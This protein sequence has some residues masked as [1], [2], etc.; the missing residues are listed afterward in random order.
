[1]SAKLVRSHIRILA[2]H[3]SDEAQKLQAMDRLSRF[4]PLAFEAVSKLGEIANEHDTALQ[5]AALRCLAAIGPAS[6]SALTNATTALGAS[7]TSVRSAAF[8]V[9]Q[10]IGPVSIPELI[11]TVLYGKS[12]AKV[13]AIRAIGALGAEGR[14][15]QS[16]LAHL[17]KT[18]KR[19]VQ[20]AAANALV[21]LE[22]PSPEIIASASEFVKELPIEGKLSAWNSLTAW[23]E[24]TKA[25]LPQMKKILTK[26][27]K[28]GAADHRKVVFKLM[29]KIGPAAEPLAENLI[30]FFEGPENPLRSAALIAAGRVGSAAPV[31]AILQ[32]VPTA[33]DTRRPQLIDALSR[34]PS[35]GPQLVPIIRQFLPTAF[36]AFRETLFAA[37]MRMGESATDAIPEVAA[38]LHDP[39]AN[40]RSMALRTL[41]KLGVPTS[42]LPTIQALVTDPQPET[43]RLAMLAI[44]RSTL[45]RETIQ[46]AL[47]ERLRDD[48]PQVRHLAARLLAQTGSLP[49][50]LLAST[51]DQLQSSYLE[52]RLDAATWLWR[53]TKDW[54]A[55]AGIF[56]Q[57]ITCSNRQ[58]RRE[59]L[60]LLEE[61]SATTPEAIQSLVQALSNP[62]EPQ[63]HPAQ[64]ALIRLGK[65]VIPAVIAGLESGIAPAQTACIGILVR[66]RVNQHSVRE[67]MKRFLLGD[68]PET[69]WA[70]AR[71]FAEFGLPE[72]VWPTMI[73]LLG[74]DSSLVRGWATIALAGIGEPII[75]RLLPTL[76]KGNPQ[77][78]IAICDILTRVG[79]AGRIALNPLAAL[80]CDPQSPAREP[81][82]RALR[83]I[84]R[85]DFAQQKPL[86][87]LLENNVEELREWAALRLSTKGERIIPLLIDRLA[88]EGR[89]PVALLNCIR[90]LGPTAAPLTPLLVELVRRR[91]EHSED[92]FA[93]LVSIGAS[94]VPSIITATRSEN[95]SV[96]IAA[97]SALARLEAA[98]AEAVPE[99]ITQLREC[100]DPTIARFITET[101]SQLGESALNGLCESAESTTLAEE[102]SRLIHAFGVIA[103]SNAAVIEQLKLALQSTDALVGL[104]AVWAIGRIPCNPDFVNALVPVLMPKL[105]DPDSAIAHQA[106]VTLGK[107][108]KQ[109]RK[110]RELLF[111]QAK[112]CSDSALD[113]HLLAIRYAV[114]PIPILVNP[115][116]EDELSGFTTAQNRAKSLASQRLI[117][118]IVGF[119]IGMDHPTISR[120]IQDIRTSGPIAVQINLIH[121]LGSGNRSAEPI[122]RETL[123]L[124]NSVLRR[125]AFRSLRNILTPKDF[126]ALVEQTIREEDTIL[127]MESLQL[128]IEDPS[129]ATPLIPSLLKLL[130]SPLQVI[131]EPAMRLL[132]E[133]KVESAQLVPALCDALITPNLQQRNWA[134]EEL[135]RFGS[136]AAPAAHL[137]AAILAKGSYQGGRAL[138]VLGRVAIPAIKDLLTHPLESVRMQMLERV[139][140]ID[141][142]LGNSL[143]PFRK[144]LSKPTPELYDELESAFDE[145]QPT[146]SGVQ[147]ENPLD[148]MKTLRENTSWYTRQAAADSLRL[149]VQSER[150]PEAH[151]PELLETLEKALKDSDNDVR[152]HSTE[153][154]VALGARA[155][156]IAAGVLELLQDNYQNVRSVAIRALSAMGDLSRIPAD[157]IIPL[158]KNK[159]I[160]P[161]A[162]IPIC[163]VLR[164]LPTIPPKAIER[165]NKF[166][167]SKNPEIRAAVLPVL[168]SI[169][170]QQKTIAAAVAKSLQSDD[171]RELAGALLASVALKSDPAEFMPIA[172]RLLA[173]RL[174]SV[175]SLLLEA[176]RE[177]GD[178]G[179]PYWQAATTEPLLQLRLGLAW[180]LINWTDRPAALAATLKRLGDDTEAS[181]RQQAIQTEAVALARA[182]SSASTSDDD[183]DFVDDEDEDD[184][185][186]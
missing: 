44:A 10:A 138:N 70:A 35:A 97:I 85:E 186:D 163:N 125:T 21:Q 24:I 11:H 127:L 89:D 26:E 136:E 67:R 93:A 139:N 7:S 118:E 25:A 9:V 71:Y 129:N 107:L 146:Q 114:E 8:R 130:S 162:L 178:A 62:D 19:D 53:W 30:P 3:R 63:G 158:L 171:P 155:L 142:R 82:L 64:N 72:S 92:V 174:P 77:A 185:D 151:L 119:L 51:R 177:I 75:Q 121:S 36:G 81:A 147:S 161:A 1:M 6:A 143:R 23:P 153:V 135:I 122:L 17:L 99:L 41:G 113:A 94:A 170:A 32:L 137:F 54:S 60:Q 126:R 156:P 66:L 124:E 182:G 50:S 165:L 34:I 105:S 175:R 47:I 83:E 106:A 102:R 152:E 112:T 128:L 31:P 133:M 117:A 172:V 43:R 181:V 184:D 164:R 140:W 120:M 80:L 109:V 69:R 28:D 123:K 110:S 180:L 45:P 4:G 111:A 56:K 87:E 74:D 38:L 68:E 18:G 145:W 37:L 65:P 150:M 52:A 73:E 86:M 134:I 169:P 91:S 166:A 58:I 179:V 14:V 40:V 22:L 76:Q 84:A 16:I 115:L 46:S 2:S 78:Q 116:S 33:G 101:L 144:R 20:K 167:D 141:W 27:P 49:E 29:A 13:H 100:D 42:S 183:D 176:A 131:R 96:R 108:T 55:S 160:E 149:M 79:P 148:V 88:R 15:S 61:I 48:V 159:N 90:L 98:A 12:A 132:R 57:A 5:F 39:N 173:C 168:A 95:R 104:E 154:V 103:R 59:T 157:K